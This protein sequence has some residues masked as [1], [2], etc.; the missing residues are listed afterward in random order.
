MTCRAVV[1]ATPAHVAR[2][3]VVP[4]DL[5]CKRLLDAVR[6]GTYTVVAIV[7]D[8][9]ELRDFRY[10]VTPDRCV[11]LVMQQASADRKVR[12]LLCY[13]AGR[14][15]AF[16]AA[17][18]DRELVRDTLAQVCALDLGLTPECVVF[19]A[20]QRWEL[21]GTVISPELDEARR[22]STP[23]ATRRVF[24]AGDYA[25]RGGWGYG[26]DDAICSGVATAD[27][28]RSTILTSR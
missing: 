2:S 27:L 6:Y 17:R 18:D 28:V 13:Y 8:A 1:L 12:T 5:A 23:R 11:S 22:E 20:V 25:C 19:T 3:L 15:L 24:I 26:M 21:A 9:P 14:S 16:A 4:L 7:A 10:M